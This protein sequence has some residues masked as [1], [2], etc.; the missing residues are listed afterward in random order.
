MINTTRTFEANSQNL[1]S[2]FHIAHFPFLNFINILQTNTEEE[3]SSVVESQDEYEE[4]E[5]FVSV[6]TKVQ[7]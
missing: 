4:G 6:N 7:C 2:H 5:T 3:T 1:L